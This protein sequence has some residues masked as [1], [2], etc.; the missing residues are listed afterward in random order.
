MK[1]TVWVALVVL[2]LGAMVMAACGGNGA[3]QQ[4]PSPPAEYANM[5]N[6][7]EGQQEAVTAGRDLYVTNCASCHGDSAAGDG[8]AGQGLD[9]RPAN[10]QE[11]VRE[12]DPN[13]SHWVITVGGSGSGLNA[14]MP[15]YQGILSDDEIWQ[16][17]TYLES[18]Y[19]Q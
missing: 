5:T 15:A 16:I 3:T 6:P 4:R 10:L 9:P 18:T 11:T 2:I 12:T 1:K 8:P 13:Y 14:A 17:V 19:G 7:F